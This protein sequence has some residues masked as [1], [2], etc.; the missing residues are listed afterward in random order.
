[1]ITNA[2]LQDKYKTQE[3]LSREVDYDVHR[4]V[5]EMHEK[6]RQLQ[7]DY[8]FKLR[9]KET[10]PDSPSESTSASKKIKL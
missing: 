4:Y 10:T 5:Q 6:V 7:S 2:I 1:M 3:K 8:G 9:H